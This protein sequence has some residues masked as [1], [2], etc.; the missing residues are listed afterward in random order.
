VPERGG[1]PRPRG[2]ADPRVAEVV[3]T[4][5]QIDPDELSPRRALDL[6]V[7]LRNKLT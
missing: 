3:A 4:L 7:E 6:L 2:A 1:S 5:R